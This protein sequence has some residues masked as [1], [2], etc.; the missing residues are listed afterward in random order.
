[1]MA[2][3]IHMPAA[4]IVDE[5]GRTLLAR[6]RGTGILPLLRWSKS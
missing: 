4:L 1:M 6:K 3:T 2:T 5:A